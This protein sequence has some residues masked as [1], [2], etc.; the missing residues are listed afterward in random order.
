M[1]PVRHIPNDPEGFG[2]VAIEAAAHGL[3]TV[4]FAT[5]GIVDAVKQ[6]ES[7]WLVEKNNYEALTKQVIETLQQPKSVE[8]CQVFA[9]GFE[10]SKFGEKIKA[11]L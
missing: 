9:K 11:Q 8:R 10:W 4:A 2:M 5:G 6:N 7:G 3:P 1:F